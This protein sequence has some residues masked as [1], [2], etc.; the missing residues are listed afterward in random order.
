[1]PIID[2][3]KYNGGPNVLAWKYPDEELSTFTQLIVNESQ[4]AVLVKEGKIADV[5]SAGRYTLDTANIPIL[6]NIINLPFG[7]K[8]PFT[9]EVW[10]IN[11]AY[12]LD[13]KWG[14][15][16]P[17]QLQDPKFGIFVPVRAHGIFGIRVT[18]SEIFLKSLVGTLS[19]LDTIALTNFFRGLYITKV[20]D[21]ISSY[22]FKQ[23][24]GIL[25]INAYLNELSN[26]LQDELHPFFQQYGVTL[27]NFYIND[28][29]VPESDEGVKQLKLALSRRA[30]M[31]IIG[32]NYQQERTFDTLE[33]AAKNTGSDGG[34]ILGTSLGMAMGVGLGNHF[35]NH[36][37]NL[38]QEL[39]PQNQPQQQGKSCIDCHMHLQENAKFCPECGH[40]QDLTCPQCQQKVE[41]EMKFCSNCGQNLK[42]E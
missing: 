37:S 25:E 17:I 12:S 27:I 3:V 24:I 1:M 8:S 30:E 33:G 38:A 23:N 18:N 10:Y 11:Q 26:F 39:N 21:V 41:P 36:F 31:D 15:M 19:S 40:K 29:S 14:T 7:G 2:L 9:A 20:K 22:L 5:F 28:I 42:G 13:I 34:S 16:T 6:N 35:A 32:Y 4:E